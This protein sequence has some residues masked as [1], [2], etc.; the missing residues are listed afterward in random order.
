VAGTA[1]NGLVSVP[2]Y[3]QAAAGWPTLM[4]YTNLIGA[5]VLVP[6]ILLVVPI[7]G[8]PGAAAVWLVLNLGYLAFNVPYMHRRLLKTEQRRWYCDDLARPALGAL[9]VV[10][11]SW[12]LAPPLSSAASVATY[13]AAT[14]LTSTVAAVAATPGLRALW[15]E[16][17]VIRQARLRDGRGVR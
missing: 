17:T 14:W 6:A 10:A 4:M 2:G 16:L 13:V 11:L 7:Y 8:A 1:V 12:L 9:P 5:C 3:L 15:R